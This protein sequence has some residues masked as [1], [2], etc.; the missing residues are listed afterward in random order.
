MD[1]DIHT[2]LVA[3]YCI[4]RGNPGI[5]TLCLENAG[6]ANGSG[7][8]PPDVVRPGLGCG[9]YDRN[10]LSIARSENST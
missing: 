7:F 1:D 8:S 5:V 2:V 6:E 10:C 4:C 9:V 3:L